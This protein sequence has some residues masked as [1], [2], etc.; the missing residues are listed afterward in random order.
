MDSLRWCKPQNN[1]IRNQKPARSSKGSC[2]F[3]MKKSIFIAVVLSLGFCPTKDPDM[4]YFRSLFPEVVFSSADTLHFGPDEYKSGSSDSGKTGYLDMVLHNGNSSYQS[5][6]F[7]YGNFYLPLV[8][9][10][11]NGEEVFIAEYGDTNDITI[12]AGKEVRIY[13]MGHY[14]KRFVRSMEIASARAGE[15]P[16]SEMDSWIT[17]LNHDGKIDILTREIGESPGWYEVGDKQEFDIRE[18]DY[19]NACTL[20]DTGFVPIDV[21]NPD[22]LRNI[23]RNHHIT[24]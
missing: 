10:T 18:E 3:I 4:N 14:G 8:R 7:R 22:S 17:D 13:V 6:E 20:S 19:M 1:L 5:E 9:G 23:Y 12:Y 24:Y 11:M 16:W 21:P 15:G 2:F